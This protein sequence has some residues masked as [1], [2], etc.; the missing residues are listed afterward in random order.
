MRSAR[1]ALYAALSLLACGCAPVAHVDVAFAY[2]TGPSSGFACRADDNGLPLLNRVRTAPA[3]GPSLVVDFLEIDAGLSTCLP[4]LLLSWC[5]QGHCHLRSTMR[6]C[7]QLQ[8]PDAGPSATL[9]DLANASLRQFASRGLLTSDAPH[10]FV[11][12]R[13]FGTTLPCSD[14]AL[15]RSAPAGAL[16]PASLLGCAYGCPVELDRVQGAVL[17]SLPTLQDNCE[18]AVRACAL[19]I[20]LR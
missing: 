9:A 12:V 3:G 8:V 6:T 7:G 19:G 20:A 11:M 13:A 5:Q 14:P 17:L 18:Q 15:S 4:D 16:S 10:G 2:T 1:W